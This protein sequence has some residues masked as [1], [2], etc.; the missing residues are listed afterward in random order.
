[1]T[2]DENLHFIQFLEERRSMASTPATKAAYTI[3]KKQ[4]ILHHR[5]NLVIFDADFRLIVDIPAKNLKKGE[6]Y[7]SHQG[8]V[9]GIGMGYPFCDERI[10]EAINIKYII[11]DKSREEEV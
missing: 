8:L 9:S 11:N 6:I 7:P 10:F 4:Y 2:S 1:M 3:V 5:K